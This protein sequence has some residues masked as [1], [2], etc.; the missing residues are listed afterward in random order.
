MTRHELSTPRQWQ[1]NIKLLVFSAVFLPVLVAL[2]IWQLDRAADKE[3]Q[4]QQ[5]QQQATSLSGAQLW[6]QDPMPGRPVVLQGRYGEFS[7]LLD[8]RTRVGLAG[9]EVLSL[10]LVDNGP[11]VVVNR[12]W[13]RAPA[14]RDTLP[15][16]P[17]PPGVVQLEGRLADFPEPPVL[18]EQ[19]AM[20]G[21]PRRVQALSAE[22][23]GTTGTPVAPLLVRLSDAGQPGAF[24]ADWQ[25]DRMGP[26]T[27]Y[28]YALQWFSLALTLLILTVVAS[29]R[30]APSP[31]G[32]VNS[33]SNVHPG[34]TVDLRAYVSA[35]AHV[36][37]S[38]SGAENDNN[39]GQRH[40]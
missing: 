17:T 40:D 32:P 15:A 38:T 24:R 26:Q 10:F 29:Y 20:A 21:W 1:P 13:L 7:W 9:Y 19:P 6:Q 37:P 27:H 35:N 12:G 11:A 8:N 30:R 39:R 36:C 16:F 34:A 4:L 5:W 25:P 33:R 2:S 3:R 23:A 22:Q 28:G 31:D 18:A 14:R